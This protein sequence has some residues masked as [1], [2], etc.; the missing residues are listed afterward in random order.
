M[1]SN[2]LV[3]GQ[4]ITTESGYLKGHGSYFSGESNNIL[5]SCVAGTIER[6]NK[7]ISVRPIQSRYLG[8]IGDLVVGRITS[9][10]SKRWKV[11]ET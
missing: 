8:E 1:L 9:V 4:P 5:T 6:T 3:P 7:L 2:L 10:D 11:N